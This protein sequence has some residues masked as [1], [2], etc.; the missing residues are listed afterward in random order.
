M[1]K[2]KFN[3]GINLLKHKSKFTRLIFSRF[4]LILLLLIIQVLILYNMYGLFYKF[5]K[6]YYIL[7]ILLIIIVIIWLINSKLDPTVKITWLSLIVVFPIL[8]V[9]I[10][11]YNESEIGHIILKKKI[12]NVLEKTKSILNKNFYN[13]GK[14]NPISNYLNNIVNYNSYKAHNLKYYK[15]GESFFEEFIKYLKEAK[16]YIFLEYF[17]IEEGLMWGNILEILI[18]KAKQGLDI[19]VIYDGTCE[20]SKLSLDYKDKLNKLNI[21][22]KVFSKLRPFISTYYNY[23]DHR[24]ICVIDGKVAFTGGVNLAD[25]YINYINKYGYFKDSALKI[26]GEAV[27]SFTLMFLQLWNLDDLNFEYTDYIKK[28]D[29][30]INDEGLIIPYSDFPLDDEKVGKN[31]YLDIIN[32]AN[33]YVY[34]MTPYLILDNELENALKFAAKKGI[35]VKIIVPKVPDHIIAHFIAKTHYIN[36]MESNVSI[37]EYTKGFIHSKVFLSD[38]IVSVVGTINMDY[39]SL[40]HNLECGVFM[41]NVGINEDIKSDFIESCSTSLK[42]TKEYVIKEYK[43]KILLGKL[44][45]I[46]APLF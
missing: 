4:S 32:R 42:L 41:Y 45:K 29:N 9:T 33:N 12:L 13:F 8:G 39:R 15:S 24:K 1:K 43:Y 5:I 28:F 21:K 38:D 27:N 22:C 23:R 35:E 10:L 25:E 26:E 40:Y 37:Y 17:I 14:Y 16:E 3:L 2:N 46:L 11:I 36:L 44:F 30:K 7:N 20:L 19:R 18:D 31:V 6:Y 34:I